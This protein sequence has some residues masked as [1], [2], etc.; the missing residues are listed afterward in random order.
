[1]KFLPE[2]NKH[3]WLWEDQSDVAGDINIGRADTNAGW[4][5]EGCVTRVDGQLLV[6]LF[7]M[8]MRQVTSQMFCRS[9]L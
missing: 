3:S 9:K 6:C 2:I 4:T 1:M 7:D 8:K 5:G